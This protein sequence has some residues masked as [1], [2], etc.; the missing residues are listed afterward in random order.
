MFDPRLCSLNDARRMRAAGVPL[1]LGQFRDSLN[2]RQHTVCTIST[3][4]FVA[5]FGG[6]IITT[7]LKITC[8]S[9]T[10]LRIC[11]F[12]LKLPWKEERPM[13]L[14]DPLSPTE[15]EIFRFPG[16][17]SG[18]YHRSEVI[19]AMPILLR[20]GMSVEGFLLAYDHDPLPDC[21]RVCVCV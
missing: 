20:H 21:R 17:R 8:E 9:K 19:G 15:T 11:E 3:H 12:A 13:L 4:Y 16:E 7:G 18:G 6:F 10:P 2:I 14:A 1:D 5:N